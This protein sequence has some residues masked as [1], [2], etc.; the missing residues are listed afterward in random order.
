MAW[1]KMCVSFHEP[2]WF[3]KLC[4]AIYRIENKYLRKLV[5][6]ILLSRRCAEVYSPALR[7][8]FDKYHQ[9]KI[10]F[11]TYGPFYAELPPGTVI[12]RY[13]SVPRE[14][15]VINGSHPIKHKSSHPFFFNPTFGHVDKLLIERRTKLVIGNDVYVGLDVIIMPSVTVIGDGA[16]IAAGSVVV[17]DVPPYAVVGGNPAKIIKYR[18]TQETIDKV[19][20]SR[21]WEKDI[22]ELKA[23]ERE[24]A[25]FLED[26]E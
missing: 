19:L 14:L 15:M 22:E 13:T 7:E 3:G 20:A 23:D 17:T 6:I 16:V 5:L 21:W 25:S 12:G 24:F 8:I 10:G 4:L 26:L 18:F 2:Q 1:K 9:V 11:Y